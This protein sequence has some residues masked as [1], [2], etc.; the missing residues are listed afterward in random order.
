MQNVSLAHRQ[1]VLGTLHRFDPVQVH[2]TRQLG[3]ARPL[4]VIA[5]T[6][7]SLAALRRWQR[8]RTSIRALE[9]LSDWQ[10]KD[11]GVARGDIRAI[12]EQQLGAGSPT[13]ATS[14]RSGAEAL[15]STPQAVANDDQSQ[16]AA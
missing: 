11:I 1:K 6:R 2:L 3:D 15:I 13:R 10:L 7:R 9:A 12:V 14:S 8:R 4:R 16:M 5:L